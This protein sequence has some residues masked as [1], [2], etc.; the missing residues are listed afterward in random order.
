MT[1]GDPVVKLRLTAQYVS[2]QR[3][4]CRSRDRI[5]AE[6]Q[7][8]SPCTV[9]GHFDLQGIIRKG[10]VDIGG[11]FTINYVESEPDISFRKVPNRMVCTGF[12]LRDFQF[13]QT[14]VFATEEINQSDTLLPNV[15]LGY[16]IYDVCYT[17]FQAIRAALSMMTGV[18]DNANRCVPH[19]SVAAIIGGSWSTQSIAVSRLVGTFNV[20]V[21]SYFST[22]AC[23]SDKHDH[24]TFLRTI[25]S[26]L[27][28]SQALVQLVNHFNWTWIGI[29]SEDNDYGQSATSL[30]KNDVTKL[31][32][33]V[34]FTEIIPTVPVA[35]KI[36]RIVRNILLYK[37]KVVLIIATEFSVGLIFQEVFYQNITGIQWIASE[38]WSTSSLFFTEQSY[39]YF[40]GTIGFAIRRADI[41]GLK[42]FL[43]GIHP[44]QHRNDPLT[45]K[46]WEEIFN[47]SYERTDNFTRLPCTG[48]ENLNA[49]DNIYL[50]MTNLRIANNVY[51]AVYAVAHALH[52]LMALNGV[53]THSVIETLNKVYTTSPYKLLRYLKSVN[54][55]TKT[56]DKVSF[57]RNGDPYPTY[58]LVNWQRGD[59]G[60]FFFAHVGEFSPD[61]NFRLDEH[62]IMW[63]GSQKEVPISMCS[64]SCPSGTRR[65]AQPGRHSCCFDCIPCEDGK[66][67][68]KSNSLECMK[69][70]LEYW[71]NPSRDCCVPKELEFISFKET[72]GS[73]LLGGALLGMFFTVCVITVFAYHRYSPIV[74][75][76][77]SDLSFCILFSIFLCFLSSV[78]YLGQPSTLSCMLRH[79]GFGI[80]FA[81]CMSCILCKTIVV[82]VA[83]NV[84]HPDRKLASFFNP[85]K[86]KVLIFLCTTFQ[87][88]VCA[89]WNIISPPRPV[90]KITDDSSSINLECNA[91]SVV[92]FSLVLGYIGILVSVCFTLAFCARNLPNHYNEAKFITF[93]MVIVSAVWISF[94]PAYLSSP[95]KY[96]EAVEMFAI[97]FSSYGLLICIFAPKCYIILLQPD[98]N[99]RRHMRAKPGSRH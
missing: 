25:P 75:A 1:S 88:I 18:G 64:P 21:I 72:L 17:H 11:I 63:H 36:S 43:L 19:P 79:T 71:S 74:R 23:L 58:D 96:L 83:F 81:L 89:S 84:Q 98:K 93:S 41:T 90:R 2:S 35:G 59:N 56:G 54:F 22:C 85:R 10:D 16:R 37:V 78:T 92:A 80:T 34:A 66:I 51:K 49:T 44:S 68:N 48:L 28:Q 94:I 8:H 99:K 32:I 40:S 5:G 65:K 50:D 45:V 42:S 69:C 4:S 87:I 9:D 20:P 30:F 39:K 7:L 77:N 67:S 73:V 70:P 95:G 47:C 53:N 27:F 3:G 31:G 86:Q 14:M 29:I 12:S 33:C 15:T 91:G 62:I 57:D 61:E 82:L 60:S 46:L 24:P 97:L 55:T 6:R 26:D 13:L 38:A 76:N 52:N